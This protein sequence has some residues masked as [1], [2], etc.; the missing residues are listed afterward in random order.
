MSGLE[1]KFANRVSDARHAIFIVIRQRRSR[2]SRDHRLA[3]PVRVIRVA[4]GTSARQVIVAVVAV[5]VRHAVEDFGLPV[6]VVVV[7]I[8]DR[9]AACPRFAR[10]LV[11]RLLPEGR[12]SAVGVGSSRD[13]VDAV[14]SISVVRERRV[15]AGLV[16]DVG[17]AVRRIVGVRDRTAVGVDLPRQPIGFVTLKRFAI[18]F[19]TLRT[20]FN[21]LFI[22]SCILL[23]IRL[24]SFSLQLSSQCSLN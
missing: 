10:E 23:I 21:K 1:D 6:L 19:F 2:S 15:C 4:F 20:I 5:S 13:V 14:V 9:V 24:M 22:R 3:V 11:G 17:R 16:Q 18:L 12:D 8:G 7:G